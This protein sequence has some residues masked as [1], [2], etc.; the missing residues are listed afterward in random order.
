MMLPV[1]DP[2]PTPKVTD[3]PFS[4]PVWPVYLLALVAILWALRGLFRVHLEKQM[5]KTEAWREIQQFKE[6]QVRRAAEKGKPE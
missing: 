2:P 3:A 4:F 1:T 5:R 6:E